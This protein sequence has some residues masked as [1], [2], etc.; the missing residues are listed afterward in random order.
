[1]NPPSPEAETLRRVKY[2]LLYESAESRGGYSAESKAISKTQCKIQPIKNKIPYFTSN[3]NNSSSN[4][5]A[6][7]LSPIATGPTPLGV[8]V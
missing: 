2:S 3:L 7:N 4:K 5:F 6:C 1:M 8:P